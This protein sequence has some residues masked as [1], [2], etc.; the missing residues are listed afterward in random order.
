MNL[1]SIIDIIKLCISVI[2]LRKNKECH[3]EI[4]RNH[5]NRERKY[6]I[7]YQE[8]NEHNKITR[9]NDVMPRFVLV[10]DKSIEV[11]IKSN[12]ADRFVLPVSLKNIGQG[13][14]F[15]VRLE[16]LLKDKGAFQYFKSNR[17]DIDYHSIC[18]Y[19][20]QQYA[21]REDVINFTV[22]CTKHYKEC[23]FSFKIGFED[24][25]GRTYTQNFKVPYGFYNDSHIFLLHHIS[26]SPVCIDN[27]R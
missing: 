20:D 26:K 12:I 27:N 21:L 3:S 19:M 22:G 8:I 14:A 18:E 11:V 4:L 17:K 16:V 5:L 9:K 13:T 24:V 15:D 6:Y 2:Q 1:S 7:E 23:K 25:D 10:L